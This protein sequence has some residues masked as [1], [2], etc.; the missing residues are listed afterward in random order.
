MYFSS[1]RV[2][3]R[4]WMVYDGSCVICNIMY[5][6]FP[7]LRDLSQRF[8]RTRTCW[9]MLCLLPKLFARVGLI[10]FHPSVDDVMMMYDVYVTVPTPGVEIERFL[11]ILFSSSCYE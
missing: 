2:R 5:V 3:H 4:F 1:H 8:D 11:K 7:N 9:S 6:C 10:E